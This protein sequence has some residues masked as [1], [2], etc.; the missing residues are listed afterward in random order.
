MLLGLSMCLVLEVMNYTK[1]VTLGCHI[2]VGR[3]AAPRICGLALN[4]HAVTQLPPV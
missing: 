4:S 2:L 3:S 1:S